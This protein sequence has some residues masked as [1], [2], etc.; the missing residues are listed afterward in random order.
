MRGVAL[1]VAVSVFCFA[2]SKTPAQDSLRAFSRAPKVGKTVIL[3]TFAWDIESDKQVQS[4]SNDLWWE[5]IDSTSRRLVA[6]G[7]VQ[8]ALV[9]IKDRDYESITL[10]EIST[11]RPN[12]RE[13][14]G[15]LLENGAIFAMRTVEGNFAKFR[16]IGYR[17][18]HDTSFK[19]TQFSR[20]GW[21]DGLLRRPNNPNYHLEIEWTLYSKSK[22]EF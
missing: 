4:S 13:I 20:R 1:L 3:G 5:Q 12:L 17:G 2:A 8:P 21:I 9:Q 15:D 7:K 22:E 18:S 10:D 11:M 19:E 14:D 16:I 6:I